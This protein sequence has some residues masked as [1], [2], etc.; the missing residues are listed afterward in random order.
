MAA[1][2][3]FALAA[4]LA[5]ALTTISGFGG[6]LVLLLVVSAIAGPKAALAATAISLLVA[7]SHRIWLYRRDVRA[8][9]TVPLLLGIV[10]GAFAGALIAA[11]I[12]D[13]I[14]QAAMIGIVG[15]GIARAWL[16]WEW[17]PGPRTIVVS[18]L[19]VG[20]LAGGAGGAGFLIGPIVL[21]AG[22]SGRRYLATIATAACAMHVA[23]IVGY[24]T[25]GLL[26]PDVLRLAALLTP[27]LL[28][29]NL[30]GDRTR[31]RIPAAWQLGIEQGAPIVCVVLALAGIA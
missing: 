31:D 15:L 2:I 9:V 16:G 18:A 22:L 10:P 20:V 13:A 6:G 4:V 17:R 27:A 7:N 8:P 30:L 3:V 14:V 29:G 26:T 12:P 24:G 11:W 21:A 5:G 19:L 1:L 25:G 23:R 28:L